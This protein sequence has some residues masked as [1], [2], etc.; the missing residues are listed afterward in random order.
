M[1]Q[2]CIYGTF[3]TTDIPAEVQAITIV[4]M[5]V[6]TALNILAYS[7]TSRNFTLHCKFFGVRIC[8]SEL[9]M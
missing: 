5:N 2:I 1:V 3:R 6:I 7:M 9:H 4:M 8:E